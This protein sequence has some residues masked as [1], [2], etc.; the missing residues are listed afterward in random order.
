MT[1][2]VAEK[3]VVTRNVAIALGII[4]GILAVSLVGVIVNYT[5]IINGKDNAITNL[6]DTVNLEKYVVWVHNQTVSQTAGNYASWAFP[7]NASGFIFLRLKPTTNNTFIRVIY[8]ASL[9][10]KGS[11][12]GGG[13]FY[14][15][16]YDTQTIAHSFE[17]DY[18]FP[19]FSSTVEIP[20]SPTTV[21]I[22]VGNT[23]SVGGSTETVTIEYHY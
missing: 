20:R 16:Q 22:R 23:N 14:F 5:L 7:V 2:K 6:A 17:A 11:L 12:F 3:K 4:C 15:Y 19:V 21:E 9:S 8:N 10:I 1:E 18:V 13:F